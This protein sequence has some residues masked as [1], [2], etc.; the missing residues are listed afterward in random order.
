MLTKSRTTAATLSLLPLL[1]ALVPGV[2]SQQSCNATSH[3][4]TAAPCCSSYGFCGS[5]ASFCF[6][7]CDP[8]GSNAL[9]SCMPEPVCENQN[10]TFQSF[11][12]ILM[13]ATHYNGNASAW[14]FILQQGNI[15]NTT[16]NELVM[17]LNQENN[18]T[19]LTS[20]RYV[21]Y[22]TITAR[23]KTGRWGGVVTAFIM[24]SDI[25]DEID[26]EFPGNH[27]TEGQ[28]NYFWQGLI[29][30][31]TAGQTTGNL[32]D[33]FDNYHDY[34]FDWQ[35]DQLQWLVDG[36]V[37]RTLTRAETTDNSTGLS[38]YPNTPSRV[39]LSLWPAG[40]S[41][42]PEG[43]V[44]WAGGMI[45]WD[46]PDYKSAGH[47]YAYI[48]SIS[49]QCADQP[50]ANI[51]SYVYGSNS[52]AFT[53]SISE[54]NETT[55]LASNGALGSSALAAKWAFFATGAAVLLSLV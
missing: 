43:T 20:T 27:T 9:T 53:P 5:G 38:R 52:S 49:V 22:G 46:D 7:G 26:W 41:S 54:T 35:E 19:L 48:D 51:T 32:T 11:D 18:G 10:I 37:V 25:K 39:Q 1:A 2:A 40:I 8:L 17:T 4:G 34:T 36:K 6:G 16:N 33:T 42:E 44:E 50:G 31:Q 55:I 15:Q 30:A 21:H 47:F 45:N 24:M 13:N 12:R 14:D 23:M 3:C 28:T 29:P